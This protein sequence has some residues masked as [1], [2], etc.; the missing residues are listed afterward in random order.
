MLARCDETAVSQWPGSA[1]QILTHLL[2]TTRVPGSG[3]QQAVERV[4][5]PLVHQIVLR[6]A[7][8]PMWLTVIE[9]LGGMALDLIAGPKAVADGKLPIERALEGFGSS[10][11][12][13]A[14]KVLV[15][16]VVS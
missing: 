3:Q 14:A 13:E 8:Q 2:V 9:Q 15:Y 10:S 16:N 4:S 7:D 12:Q 1:S 5:L 11:S 6:A